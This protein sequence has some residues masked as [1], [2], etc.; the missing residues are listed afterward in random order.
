LGL[1]SGEQSNTRPLGVGKPLSLDME[2]KTNICRSPRIQQNIHTMPPYFKP[3]DLFTRYS[4][5]QSLV[6]Y[7]LPKSS[8][9]S[10]YVL[11]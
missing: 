4:S 8:L 7:I 2:K 10:T 9:N 6:P 11:R 5:L 1:G 3:L